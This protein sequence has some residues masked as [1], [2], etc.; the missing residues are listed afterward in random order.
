MKD[1]DELIKQRNMYGW[2]NSVHTLTWGMCVCVCVCVY[3]C[4]VCMCACV[5]VCVCMYHN[6]IW[7]KNHCLNISENGVCAYFVIF[8]LVN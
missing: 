5:C 6:N 7:T 8:S 3:V 1:C 2:V 4:G